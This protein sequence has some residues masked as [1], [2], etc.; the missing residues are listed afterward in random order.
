MVVILL[1]LAKKNI[2]Y[3]RLLYG[4]YGNIVSWG[5]PLRFV[6]SLFFSFINIFSKKYKLNKLVYKKY[7]FHTKQRGVC[8]SSFSIGCI[9]S[10]L[11]HISFMTLARFFSLSNSFSID[12]FPLTAVISNGKQRVNSSTIVTCAVRAVRES[13]LRS[14]AI[15]CLPRLTSAWQRSPSSS[16]TSTT[17]ASPMPVRQHL[18]RSEARP[19]I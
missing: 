13:G 18:A 10:N 5:R 7:I 8:Y 19:G 9:V 6:W 14:I 12:A 11:T 3:H 17:S 15:T 2:W 4:N 1:F 16:G